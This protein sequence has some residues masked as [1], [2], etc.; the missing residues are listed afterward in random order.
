MTC[1][2]VSLSMSASLAFL[3]V[4]AAGSE[5]M[6][7]QRRLSAQIPTFLLNS[8][9]RDGEKGTQ[10]QVWKK[11]TKKNLCVFLSR[12]K[13]AEGLARHE[14]LSLQSVAVSLQKK[15]TTW[16]DWSMPSSSSS[17]SLELFPCCSSGW[18]PNQTSPQTLCREDANLYQ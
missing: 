9:V 3:Y 6:V 12:S 4:S 13:L 15:G 10:R 11:K 2:F 18:H 16:L 5:V 14:T 1:R 8:S 7:I 17:S